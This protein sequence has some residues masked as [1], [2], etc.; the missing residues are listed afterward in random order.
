MPESSTINSSLSI[1]PRISLTIHEPLDCPCTNPAQ[2]LD[3]NVK[4]FRGGLVFKADRLLYNSTLGLIVIK[5]R[6]DPTWPPCVE[7]ALEK[8]LK[9]LACHHTGRHVVFSTARGTFTDYSQVD[10]LGSQY[11]SV[12]FGAKK[13]LYTPP[14]L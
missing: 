6:E 2:L 3:R 1:R 8:G 14:N 13:G 7:A 12:N 10:I 5:K 9:R 11:K 4:R